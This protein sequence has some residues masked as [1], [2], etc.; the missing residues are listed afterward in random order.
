MEIAFLIPAFLQGLGIVALVSISYDILLHQRIDNRV[1]SF[2]V[3]LIFTGAVAGTMSLPIAVGSG[4][5]FDLRHVLL[6]LAAPFGGLGAAMLTG[7][8]AAIY[9]IWLGGAGALAGV[10]GILISVSVGVFSLRLFQLRRRT[11]K[12][13]VLIGLMP[14]CSLLSLSLL[15]PETAAG[16]LKAIA[17]PMIVSNFMGAIVVLSLLDRRKTQIEREAEL[18]ESAH[19]D[20]LT[21]IAN[22]LKLESAAPGIIGT[23]LANEK[24]VALLIMD[25]DHFKQVNDTFGHA[26]GDIILADVARVLK[27]EMREGD[28]IARYG[29]EEFVAVIAVES[30]AEAHIAAERICRSVARSRHEVRGIRLTVTISIGLQMIGEAE[31]SLSE[32]MELADSALYQAKAKGRNRVELAKA[33]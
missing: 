2:L 14:S 21:G 5:Y 3:A 28:L 22:R 8:V 13:S 9:R 24:K 27:R 26:S 20:A 23:A 7:T 32:M 30:E 19:T 33:A 15:P 1:R 31:S 17:L 18:E 4:V 6:V 10:A 12:R 16:V 29:G 11:F 25:I